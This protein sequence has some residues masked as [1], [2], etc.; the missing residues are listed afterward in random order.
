MPKLRKLAEKHDSVSHQEAEGQIMKIGY[1]YKVRA[2][3]SDNMRKYIRFL[4][5]HHG[6]SLRKMW[7]SSGLNEY[8]TRSLSINLRG[9]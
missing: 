2:S 4:Q 6:Y 1:R 8:I 3:T 7:D 9:V 5:L